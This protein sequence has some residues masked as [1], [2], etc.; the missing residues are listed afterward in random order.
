MSR[1]TLL[2]YARNGVRAGVPALVVDY[3]ALPIATAELSVPDYSNVV[4]LRSQNTTTAWEDPWSGLDVY[5]LTTDA[6]G[7]SYLA[8]GNGGP[9]VSLP[10]GDGT[11]W[12]ASAGLVASSV[13]RLHMIGFR[14]G[15]G[16]V[17]APVD[18]GLS[19]NVNGDI[20]CGWSHVD[21]GVFY[22]CNGRILRKYTWNG[23]TLT[24][25][26]EGVWPKDLSAFGTVSRYTWMTHDASDRWFTVTSGADNRIVMW[27]SVADTVTTLNTADMAGSIPSGYTLDEGYVSH[28]GG[29]VVVKLSP[30]GFAIYDLA[31]GNYSLCIGHS[32]HPSVARDKVFMP[33][34][35]SVT[36][37]TAVPLSSGGSIV[38]GR[39]EFTA[40]AVAVDGDDVRSGFRKT[41][42]SPTFGSSRKV[43]MT[44]TH[45]SVS[46]VQGGAVDDQWWIHGGSNGTNELTWDTA[47]AVHSGAV[48]SRTWASSSRAPSNVVYGA[49]VASVVDGQL[50]E[51]G[52]LGAV[53]AGTWYADTA[54]RTLYVQLADSGVVSTTNAAVLVRAEVQQGIYAVD[55]V[56]SGTEDEYRAIAFSH[57]HP[58]Q[59][60][61]SYNAFA[62]TSP[63]GRVCV[64]NSDFGRLTGA[65][66]ICALAMPTGGA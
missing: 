2:S 59:N 19:D 31:T 50:T 26:V 9:W 32:S 39:F 64:F 58:R 24:E 48:Y 53:T 60:A 62:S 6:E 54:T 46:H 1:L 23:T 27:D 47:W 18:T 61:Y 7:S 55:P 16:R 65:R 40:S 56:G 3:T 10:D 13:T 30:L 45:S 8:Y 20:G 57:I 43:E 34:G 36:D 38:E 28:D 51:V 35:F 29:F 25:V 42:T 63:D 4:A 66:A 5:R 12:V 37:T 11:Y 44:V 52:S 14:P 41:H 21:A 22:R 49:A 15:V 17:G 33:Y